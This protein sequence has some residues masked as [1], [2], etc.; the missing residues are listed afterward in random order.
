MRMTTLFGAAATALA[1]SGALAAA[2][3][4]GPAAVVERYNSSLTQGDLD[5][6]L[7]TLN[8]QLIMFNCATD[9][10]TSWEPHLFLADD[11]VRQWAEFFV[12]EAGPHEGVPTVLSAA[13]R[14]RLSIVVTEG[15][16]RN[17][18]RAWTDERTAWLVAQ[19]PAGPKVAG[20]CIVMPDAP[21]Q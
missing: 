4:D 16:G 21:A 12:K 15:D 8:S 11:Q 1:V 20:F 19:T 10:L 3:Q 2:Q 7:S 17:K 6:F 9:D 18:F 5:G 13:A 14:S